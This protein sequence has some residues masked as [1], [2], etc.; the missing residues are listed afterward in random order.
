MNVVALVGRIGS[1]P[2]MRYTPSGLAITK[3]RL[4]VTRQRKSETGEQET[5]WLDVVTFGKTAEF[6][7][8]YLDKGAHVGVTGRIQSRTWEAQ[9]GSKRYAVEIIAEN[10]DFM[11]SKQE[12]ERRRAARSAREGGAPAPQG[13]GSAYLP[14]AP[15]PGEDYFGD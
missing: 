13:G 7:S 9:D 2:E 11:E 6:V 12:A 5:D 8:Q 4:G 3:F 1:D 14:D 10:V 15:P